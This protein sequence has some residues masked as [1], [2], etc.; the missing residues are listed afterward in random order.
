[1]LPQRTTR[2]FDSNF[3]YR[4][5]YCD[6][7]WLTARLCF[8][9]AVL[10]SVNILLNKRICV[11]RYVAGEAEALIN[12]GYN[13]KSHNEYQRN[14]TSC[15]VQNYT[16]RILVVRSRYL[17]VCW[18]LGTWSQDSISDTMSPDRHDCA[19]TNSESDTAAVSTP[20]PAATAT[21]MYYCF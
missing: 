6:I 12:P 18:T 10:R 1:M 21:T 16:A 15:K 4:A 20:S 5:L 17:Q 13:S 19:L 11:A 7:Y 3:I 14:E 9:I 8:Y 2:L